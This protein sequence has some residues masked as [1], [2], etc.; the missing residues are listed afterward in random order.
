MNSLHSQW[1]DVIIPT[2]N[3]RDFL[4]RAVKSVRDQTHNTARLI[5]VDQGSTDGS[6]EFLEEQSV[7][8]FHE[9]ELGAGF[10]RSRG[11][12]ETSHEALLFLDS[13]DWLTPDALQLLM[14]ALDSSAA[15]I[16]FG[17]MVNVDLSAKHGIVGG[18]RSPAPLASSSLLRRA[19][20]EQFGGFDGDNFSFPRWILRSRAH[21]LVE[22]VIPDQVAFRGFHAGN[23]SRQSHAQR[24]LFDLVR[25]HRDSLAVE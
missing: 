12:R 25:F 15:D 3:R 23:E 14:A 18:L 1:V 19:A 24:H 21:G 2:L 20:L 10:A 9:P 4:T 8:W 17:A 13:D 22:Q 5:V 16:A 7:E 6:R 11:L